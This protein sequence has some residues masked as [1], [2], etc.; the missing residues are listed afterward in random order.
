MPWQLSLQTL[1]FS[2]LHGVA[3]HHDAVCICLFE[4]PAVLTCAGMATRMGLQ[5]Q[6]CGIGGW[7][8]LI[9][10]CRAMLPSVSPPCH[11][12]A[13]CAATDSLALPGGIPFISSAA[14]IGAA[15]GVSSKHETV[16][17]R[18]L[19]EC[20]ERWLCSAHSWMKWRS[21]IEGD[22]SDQCCPGTG[23][24][25]ILHYGARWSV[26]NTTWSWHKSWYHNAFD[27]TACP[28]WDLSAEHP[29][30]GRFPLPPRPLDIPSEVL[31]VL[32]VSHAVALHESP[33]ASCRRHLLSFIPFPGLGPP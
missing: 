7:T 12:A 30:A 22:S 2:L 14:S 8:T 23:P 4:L 17:T 32:D 11:T 19:T 20:L 6:M 5:W 9:P 29:T 26:P 10:C 27:V 28:P 15:T 13:S 33:C 25:K 18:F 1:H 31:T 3:K 16:V 24:P 21:G